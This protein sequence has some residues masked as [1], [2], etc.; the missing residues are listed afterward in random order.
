MYS[1]KYWSWKKFPLA[2]I[3]V[4][5]PVSAHAG[6]SAQPP[7]GTIGIFPARV[8]AK[9]P[10]NISP[11][12][13]EVISEVLEL[14]DKPFLDIFDHIYWFSFKVYSVYTSCVS[15][16]YIQLLKV[17]REGSAENSGIVPGLVISTSFKVLLKD[18]CIFVKR[19]LNYTLSSSQ[20][21]NSSGSGLDCVFAGF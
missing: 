16:C 19:F 3:G 21:D 15:W 14:Y 7:I 4:L 18:I 12:P 9:L 6:P 10:S 13:L 1:I 17:V 20:F 2:P 11:N 5:A 8:S